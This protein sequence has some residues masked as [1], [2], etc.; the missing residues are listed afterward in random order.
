M[1]KSVRFGDILS[2]EKGII[3]HGCNAH[4]VMGSGIALQIKSKWP[5]CYELYRTVCEAENDYAALLGTI[6]PYSAGPQ[7]VVA[8]AITQLDFG[9]YP[10]R[11]VSYEAIQ[12]A[13]ETIA[14]A[15]AKA[16]M[17]VH[18]PLIGAGLGG[19]DWSIISEI[20]DICFSKHPEVKRTLWIYD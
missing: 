18:Y 7:L 13:F 17:E 5:E 3:V 2:A 4:G 16:K 19:G 14:D 11:Y 10:K 12:K 1:N 15:A 8:N 20:I 6:V 9:K